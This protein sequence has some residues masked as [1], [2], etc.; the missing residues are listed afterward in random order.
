ML[1]SGEVLAEALQRLVREA[2][3]DLIVA[4]GDLTD[5]GEFGAV[6]PFSRGN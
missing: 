6:D 2:D 4:S 3:P 1:T 5:R